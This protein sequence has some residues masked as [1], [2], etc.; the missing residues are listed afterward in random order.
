MKN[1]RRFMCIICA[2]VLALSMAPVAFGESNSVAVIYYT[3]DVH[4]AYENMAKIQALVET[5][6][7]ILVDAGDAI[8]GSIATSLT[9]GEAMVKVMSAMDYAVA[10]PGNHEFDYGMERFLQVI[11]T[12]D[13]TY[14]STN[15]R[16]AEG[17]PKTMLQPYTIVDADG[18][19]TT[20]DDQ[21]GF[22]GVTTPWT[23]SSSM[24]TNFQDA[25]GNWIYDFMGDGT[26]E[27]LFDAVQTA[28]DD[29][30][31]D[32]ADYLVAITHMGIVEGTEPYTTEALIQNTQGLDAVIDGHSHVVME[33][34]CILDEAG[35][36]VHLTQT[37]TKLTYV[38]RLEITMDGT[39]RSQLIDVAS[40]TEIDEDIQVIVD[41]ITEEIS[42]ISDV[43]VAKSDVD[44]WVNDPVTGVRLVRNSETNLGDMVA[45]AYREVLD[46]DISLVN[47]GGIRANI[48]AGDITNGEIIAVHPFGNTCCVAEATGQ[49]ILDALEQGVMYY[50]SE[51]GS[52]LHVSGMT[53]EIHSYIPS[54][55]VLDELGVFVSVD[56]EYRVKNMMIGGEPMDLNKT[57]TVGSQNYVLQSG[58]YSMFEEDDIVRD[59]VMLDSDLLITYIE[60]NLNGVIGKENYENPYGEG[61]IRIVENAPTTPVT[62]GMAIRALYA[63]D[64]GDDAEEIDAV[65]SWAKKNKV[66]AGYTDGRFGEADLVSREQLATLLHNYA[67]Y[68]GVDVSVG[69]NTNILSYEDVFE[70]S[71]YAFPAL[72]WACGA[73]ILTDRS[74]GLLNPKGGVLFKDLEQMIENYKNAAQ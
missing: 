53:Y 25:Q 64:G 46:T 24:P 68:K 39:I 73:D 62:R 13:I 65:I 7:S 28:I 50:P 41:E 72:Q 22:I 44:L 3:N 17:E 9:D 70:T 29:A 66:A 42:R 54:S 6:P 59:E 2:M 49:Q 14:L 27:L 5:E 12:S 33:E 69:E 20:Q 74:N 48:L 57:Y 67:M 47:G 16:S 43:V 1:V 58:A 40:L 60:E 52:F 19:E 45:D 55:V 4:G 61:R 32:G 26:G 37:G 34:E 71:G 18:D 30:K 23:L 56:G 38:G 35:N 10:V 21:I 31:K 11:E 36:S 51:S 15:F 8:Q 63:L